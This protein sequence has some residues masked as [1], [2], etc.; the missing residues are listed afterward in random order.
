M[1]VEIAKALPRRVILTIAGL[2]TLCAGVTVLVAFS[3]MQSARESAV[4]NAE[5]QVL[6]FATGAQTSLNRSLLGVD[7]ML[8]SVDDLLQ[9]S[10]RGS[11]KMETEQVSRL[12]R[13]GVEQTMLARNVAVLTM[14]GKVVASSDREG[15][16]LTV[17][18]PPGFL[19][20]VVRSPVY[21]V[22][23]SEP[24]PGGDEAEPVIYFARVVKLMDQSQWV[25]VAQVPVALLVTIMVQGTGGSEL[26]VT[27]ERAD[28]K[29]LASAPPAPS[30]GP[31]TEQPSLAELE[32]AG[33]VQQLQSRLTSAPALIA[34]RGTLYRGL[35]LTTALPLERALAQ[36]RRDS[37]TVVTAAAVVLALILLAGGF[38]LWYLSRLGRATRTLAESKQVLDQ[39]LNSMDSGFVLADAQN[40]LLHWNQRYEQMVPGLKG[41]LKP[42]MSFREAF[43]LVALE[44]LPDADAQTRRAWT[45][46]REDHFLGSQGQREILYPNGSLVQVSLRRTPDG[47]TVGVISDVTAERKDQVSLRIAAIAFESQEGMLVTDARRRILRVNKAFSDITSYSAQDAVGHY[48]QWLSSGTQD[49]AFY[50]TLRRSVRDLGNWQGEMLYQ[51][52]TGQVFPAHLTI[53]AVKDDVG[54]VTHFVITLLDITQRKAAAEEI[55]RLAYHDALTGL[56]NRRLLMDRLQQ[57]L[58]SSARTGRHGALLFLDLDH[59]KVLNDTC[60]HDVGDLLLR[61]VAQ[62]LSSAVREGDTVARLGGDEFVVL[63]ENLGEQA[64][65]AAGQSKTVG[66]KVLAQLG[67][68]YAIGSHQHHGS[69]SIGAVLFSGQQQ[70]VDD[71]LKQADLAMYDVK[72]AGRN[73]LRYFDPQMQASISARAAMQSELRLALSAQQFVL[74]YQPQVTHQGRVLGAEALIRWQHPQRGLVSPLAFIPLAEETGQ[75]LPMGLWVLQSACAQ[76][77]T[78]ESDARASA[79]QLAVNVSAR[80]FHQADFVAQVLAVLQQ[81]GA[82]AHL[83]KLELTESVVLKD[84]VDA[85]AKM[86]ALKALGVSFSLDDF[87]TGQSSLS[88]LTQLPLDQIKIDQS[89]VRHMDVKPADA[90]MVQTI[91]GMAHNLGLE[92]IAEGVETQA[93]RALLEQ[94]GCKLCQGYL[95]GRP[96][97]LAEFERSL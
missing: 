19:Q 95:F 54:I 77:K 62:R 66:E 35:W 76:L 52:K 12:L 42:L 71:L 51:R 87:G 18:L 88:Y 37:K 5:E 25:T 89:F 46:A 63:L 9:A 84:V 7:A 58:S 45:Q 92:V 85:S 36:W 65:E 22:S 64:I 68:A 16:L 61:Q 53:T 1:K 44:T 26:E 15:P 67:Q 11:N 27:L 97:P 33:T 59:F 28:G 40:R 93:Q 24:V 83:L 2:V 20:R 55:E 70:S 49:R 10:L 8:A 57:A 96:V 13:S 75:I 74:Y 56:P 39:A 47:G 6:R 69:C 50:R 80:Q 17:A 34:A 30:V 91:I 90:M 78:W 48:P 79:L 3:V 14:D 41:R 32:S 38:A 81:T 29:L 86:N 60:G 43:E 82:R 21:Q 94:H 72:T 31:G 4:A 23:V 73:A